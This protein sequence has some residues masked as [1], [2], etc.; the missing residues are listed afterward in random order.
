MIDATLTSQCQLHGR[1]T[2]RKTW[3]R[4]RDAACLT[5]AADELGDG[6]RLE[7]AAQCG[8]RQ[9]LRVERDERRV[10]IPAQG[11]C[12]SESLL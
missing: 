6:R 11:T 12:G 8:V 7:G 2:N 9:L 5:E 3:A 1:C 4:Q 10:A